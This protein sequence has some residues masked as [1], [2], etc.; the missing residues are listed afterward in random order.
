[1]RDILWNITRNR[2][3]SMPIPFVQDSF[4]GNLPINWYPEEDQQ[5]KV[6]LRQRPGLSAP[7]DKHIGGSYFLGKIECLYVFW[8]QPP[9]T[10]D[11]LYIVSGTEVW[12]WNS[13]AANPTLL[14][15]MSN[16][17]SG[18]VRMAD[19]SN[20][21]LVQ[22]DAGLFWYN[23]TTQGW[24]YNNTMPFTAS[25]ITSQDGYFIAPESGTGQ[26]YFSTDGWTW[27]AGD[28]ATAESCNDSIIRSISNNQLLWLFGNNS[29][30]IWYNSGDVFPFTRLSSGTDRI[31]LSAQSSPAI[32]DKNMI[33][34]SD[35]RQVRIATGINSTIISNRKLDRMFE[36]Y[37]IV[38]DAFALSYVVGGH[39]FYHLTFPTENKTW[40]YD[41][42]TKMWHEQAYL[43]DDTDNSNIG[44]L[45]LGKH[46]ISS[47]AYFDGKHIVG[48]F[49]NGNLYYMDTTA[50][51]DNGRELVRELDTPSFEDG[52]DLI[53]IP[54][55]RV[56]FAETGHAPVT[57][58]GSDPQCMLKISRDG[59]NTWGSERKMSMG[60]TGEY[61]KQIRWMNNG[62][63]RH[64][65]LRLRV[66]D[67]VQS[68]M[69]DLVVQTVK[70]S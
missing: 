24:S 12:R 6:V 38:S 54:E 4:R 21:V 40:V 10:I 8:N 55:I 37:A 31:G 26:V 39:W 3:D 20:I 50:F 67:P 42:A 27:D 36:G 65:V 61:G 52:G 53:S 62:S 51:D 16:H 11:N 58:Q 57:G 32:V 7:I 1:M 41:H 56:E 48:D 35:K 68:T 22:C 59:G 23:K 70:G 14:G 29:L 33:W 46:R 13:F 45:G 18:P 63:G 30:E 60:Q 44:L 9:T 15:E 64:N 2:G 17:V 28:V 25:D 19:I 34:L 43:Y 49:E 69:T 47:Y 66:T 5:K